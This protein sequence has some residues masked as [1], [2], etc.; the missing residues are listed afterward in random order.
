MNFKT[1]ILIYSLIGI[2]TVALLLSVILFMNQKKMAFFD[3]NKVYNSCELKTSLEKDLEK[4][5]SVRKSNLDS[6]Q[7][8]LSIIST[9]VESGN[10]SDFELDDFENQKSRFLSLQHNYEQE[11]IRLKEQYFTQIRTHIN[12]KASEYGELNNYSFLFAAVGDGA[13][14]HGAESDDITAEFLEYVNK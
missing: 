13:M 9:K 2:S 12:E 5:V 1:K 4:V 6:L 3:Y 8:E 11:N 14:M 10:A 7:M